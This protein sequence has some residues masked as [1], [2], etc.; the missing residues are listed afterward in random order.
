MAKKKTDTKVKEVDPVEDDDLEI[1]DADI[2]PDID[3]DIDPEDLDEDD[4]EVDI[5]ADIE[6][7]ELDF[8]E[9]VD[10][11]GFGDD[12]DDEE[13]DEETTEALEEL[14]SQELQ[15]LD[16]EKDDNLLVDEVEML[17]S[18][19]REELTMNVDAQSKR[20][21][22][23]VCQSCFML[24]RTSQLANKRKQLCADCAD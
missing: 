1:D 19:R 8:E 12:E 6:D 10:A 15:L 20:A 4:L 17:R 16:E 23:F 22:E 11:V 2:E 3:P 5:E 9:D 21:D 7:P 13:Q 14:E 24:K 18:I